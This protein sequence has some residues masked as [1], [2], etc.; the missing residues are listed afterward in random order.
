MARDTDPDKSGKRRWGRSGRAEEGPSEDE[1]GW[2]ADLRGSGSRQDRGPVPADEASSGFPGR[3]RRGR[4]REATGPM[5]A[6]GRGATGPMPAGGREAGP[7]PAGG[8]DVT[9]GLPAGGRDLS[10]GPPTG[11]DVTGVMPASGRDVTGSMPAGR[12]GRGRDP[13]DAPPSEPRTDPRLRRGRDSAPPGALLPPAAPPPVPTLGAGTRTRRATPPPPPP[14]PVPATGRGGPPMGPPPG[15]GRAGPPTGLLGPAGPPS[16]PLGPAGGGGPG[17]GGKGGPKLDPMVTTGMIRRAEMRRQLRVAQ[18]L[19]VATLVVV[20]VLLLAAY[21][22]YLFT[23][24]VAQDPIFGELDGLDLPSWA[25]TQHDDSFGGSRW[26]IGQCRYRE[27]TWASEHKVEETNTV[28]G[29]AL[30]DAGWRLRTGG[31]CPTV[32][33]GVATCWAH[34]EYVMDMWVR[35]PIC[36]L[37]P[38][39]PSITGKPKPGASPSPTPKAASPSPAATCP[40]ALV[41][42]KVYNAIDYH[43]VD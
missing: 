41:T 40:A 31:I 32:S 37:P 24:A 3:A 15:P 14:P 2:L 36:D 12:R 29:T 5:P 19:K 9:G 11:R 22:V 4:G 33:E 21:P 23:R 17:P 10:G 16:G 1:L 7:M 13:V 20:A 30:T 38:P 27:R 39:R 28:Y 25:T 6:G 18:Q 34:D 8:R 26:C 43:A 42:V 35:A